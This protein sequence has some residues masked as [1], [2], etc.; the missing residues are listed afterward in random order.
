MK[1]TKALICLL[2]IILSGCIPT[3]IYPLYTD[4]DVVFDENLIGKWSKDNVVWEFKR[5]DDNSYEIRRYDNFER[6]FIG[7]LVEL[8]NQLFLD[9]FPLMQEEQD[10]VFYW[11]HLQL[12][13]SFMKIGQI[14]PV[15]QMRMMDLNKVKSII[16]ESPNPIEHEILDDRV[17]FTAPTEQLQEFVLDNNE[18]D[19]LFGDT[20]ELIRHEPL[21]TEQDLVFDETLIG[22]WEGNDSL[23]KIEWTDELYRLSYYGEDMTSQAF[24]TLIEFEGLTIFGLFFDKTLVENQALNE[25]VMIPDT[26]MLVEQQDADLKLELVTYDE[27]SKIIQEDISVLY[28][29]LD[30]PEMTLQRIK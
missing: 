21:Y 11:W 16:N 12:T 30:D 4:K 25:L 10:S 27:F 1:I 24:A 13:H 2:P 7:H 15:L 26:L 19:E 23:L 22:I 17:L 5:G 8:E 3:S 20:E 29:K 18:T 9:V 14:E 28:E 6:R